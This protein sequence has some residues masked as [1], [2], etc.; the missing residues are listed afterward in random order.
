M[1]RMGGQDAAF[2]YGET[3]S[4][5]MHISAL[6]LLDPSTAP[7]E[8]TFERLRRHTAERIPLVP[9]FR[10]KLVDVPFGL[11]RPGWVEERDF[12][13]DYHIRRIAVPAPGG[14][15]ELGELVGRL[16]S[17]KLDRRK[18]LWEM[19]VIEGVEGGRV[20]V[21]YKIHHAIV[22]GVSGMGLAEVSFDL[23]PDPPPRPIETVPYADEHVPNVVERFGLGLVNATTRVPY[24]MARFG[25][26]SMLQGRTLVDFARRRRVV[27]PF[28]AP[29]TSLN[30]EF[31]PHRRFAWV[32]VPLSRTKA[33]KH[34]YD[35]KLNDVVLALCAGSLR[36]YLQLADQLPTEP[37]IA[38]VP[39]SLR[40]TG[41]QEL[42]SKV[43]SMFVNLAT[44]VEDPAE[45]LLAIRESTSHAKEMGQALS[46]DKIM[47]LTE[48]TPPGLVGLAA[49][50]YTRAG[51]QSRI[52]PPI[53]VVISN[54]PGP[55]FPL[56]LAG[57]RLE[58]MYPMGPLL[59]GT[60]LNITVISYRDSLDFGFLCCPEMVPEPR[61]IAE[62]ITAT[63]D[64]LDARS[65]EPLPDEVDLTVT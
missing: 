51:L 15:Q 39:V 57:A 31:T 62:G 59:L 34:A 28:Q 23:E 9:Q 10:L 40:G 13:L 5:H 14:P 12:D 2:L 43:G 56:Y 7:G 19:W 61:L 22:D 53:N 20:A 37:L 33:I 50:M 1:R 60:G 11:D 27:A 58:A 18:P 8:F 54:V 46:A 48:T 44:D 29:R 38:Q 4:W 47:G 42:G 55:P 16:A 49:R 36:R 21:L 17:Y 52:P 35:V 30:G 45:R 24:R 65:A 63:L 26:Q 25:W 32:S 64:Q 6:M 41:N 3:P